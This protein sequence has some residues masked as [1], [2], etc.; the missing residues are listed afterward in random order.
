MARSFFQSDMPG[1]AETRGGLNAW[2]GSVQGLSVLADA[3]TVRARAVTPDAELVMAA[4]RQ[5]REFLAL[6]ERV[7]DVT[8]VGE[9]RN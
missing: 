3:P 8:A 2:Q 1:V 4:R 9:R 6:V 5:P 7:G